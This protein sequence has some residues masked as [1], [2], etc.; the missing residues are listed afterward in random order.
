MVT[1][2]TSLMAAISIIGVVDAQDAPEGIDQLI[3]QFNLEE[4]LAAEGDEDTDAP[5]IEPVGLNDSIADGID[6]FGIQTY[7][8]SRTQFDGVT[9]DLQVSYLN[10]GLD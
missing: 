5:K 4:S 3:Q 9:S 8:K 2:L 1:V 6:D 10:L 7:D